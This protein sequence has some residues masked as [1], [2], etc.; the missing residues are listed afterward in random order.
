MNHNLINKQLLDFDRLK[1]LMQ[2][3]KLFEKGTATLWDDTHISQNMLKAHLTPDTDAA[4]RKESIINST[5]TW[6]STNFLTHK[7]DILDL[8]CG[9]GLYTKKL[10]ALGHNVVGID[11]SKRSIEYA[12]NDAKNNNHTIQYVYQNYLEM[13][14]DEEFDLIILIY[15]DFGVLNGEERNTLLAKIHKALRPN[16]LF[17]FDIFNEKYPTTNKCD[18]SWAIETN[19]FWSENTYLSLSETFHYPKDNAFVEQ[20]AII[21]DSGNIKI[22]RNWNRY[23]SNRTISKILD[24]FNFSKHKFYDGLIE[25]SNFTSSDV[26]FVVSQKD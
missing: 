11:F 2:Q 7:S 15:C 13:N 6:M 14:Y 20:Y 5:I 23:Y 9:P 3:P 1:T 19:G 16:G 22:Y 4:S 10:A 26:T 25:T 24:Q 18:N 12:I 21:T 17:I 8:G